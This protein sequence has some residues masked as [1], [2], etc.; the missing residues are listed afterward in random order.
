M[1]MASVAPCV[2]E[3]SAVSSWPIMC[4]VQ[5]CVTPM[6]IISFR[7]SVAESMYSDIVS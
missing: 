3:C 1:T 6:R 5:S 2:R 7:A 4:V